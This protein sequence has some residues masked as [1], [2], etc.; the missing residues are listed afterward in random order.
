MT[1]I[2][3]HIGKQLAFSL[4]TAAL[5]SWEYCVAG[6]CQTARWDNIGPLTAEQRGKYEIQAKAKLEQ[7][8]GRI[9]PVAL[10][11]AYFDDHSSIPEMRLTP[12]VDF[13]FE[14]SN[15][16][17]IISFFPP[18]NGRLCYFLDVLGKRKMEADGNQRAAEA[19]RK[20]KSEKPEGHSGEFHTYIRKVRTR[21][22]AVKKAE[23]IMLVI[24]EIDPAKF[25]LFTCY[26]LDGGWQVWFSARVGEYPAPG[27]SVSLILA[28]NDDLN[29][30]RYQNS[31]YKWPEP[32]NTVAKIGRSEARELGDKYL[33]QY[34]HKR[35]LNTLLFSTN[36]L[37]IITPNYL[38]TPRYQ[39]S[40]FGLTNAPTL[41]WVT[42]YER[43]NNILTRT[44]VYI[45][46]DA[47]DG[48]M[49]GGSE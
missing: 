12:D 39:G 17:C 11:R 24:G 41:A 2:I 13:Y 35:E 8:K 28:D 21:E 19:N 32:R 25:H 37:E 23:Q 33:N 38:F 29:L 18:D 26:P 49:L 10:F 22:D 7:I 5:L 40:I 43:K 45:F 20:W 30:V 14:G 1:R 16:D 48:S 47:G 46:I 31:V 3:D 27:Y 44:P 36:K 15:T 6:D 34:Y 42:I 4:F 9:T